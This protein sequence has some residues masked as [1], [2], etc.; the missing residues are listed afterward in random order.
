M[1]TRLPS[2][3]LPAAPHRPPRSNGI[4][5]HVAA[6]ADRLG[7]ALALIVLIAVFSTVAPYF[8]SVDNLFDVARQISVTAILG[9]GLTFVIMTGGIDLSV[10]SAVGVTAFVAVALSINGAPAPV[11]LLGALAAGLIIGL[12][13]GALVAGLGLA[14][15]IVTLA[16]LTYLRGVTYVGTDGKTLFSTDLG[17]AVL[18]HGSLLGVPIPVLV[19][20]AVFAGGW[21]LLNRTVFGRWVRAV[22]GNAEAARL[23]GIP[24][25]RVLTTVYVISGI[26][27]AVGGIIASARLQSAVPDLGAGYEL[28]AI[29]AVVL[30]GTSLMG[31]RGSLI[32]TLVGAAIIGVLVNGMTLLDVS[33][34]YQ[35]IIQGAVIVLAV[36][37]DRL[38][39]KSSGTQHA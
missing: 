3:A 20:A 29:A 2:P 19:M 38:R 25:R 32:G 28:S 27:A 12:I 39:I 36:A 22:G 17:Y 23:A 33:T 30:G 5:H 8:L 10:G 24:V 16:A 26:C 4:R 35:Q 11:A 34:F 13:N 1:T 15:F 14:S 9:A 31:G 37:L 7:V 6:L 21:Y 18:G